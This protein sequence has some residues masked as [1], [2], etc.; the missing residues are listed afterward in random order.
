MA[1]EKKILSSILSK[2]NSWLGPKILYDNK[3][4]HAYKFMYMYKRW[5]Y[6][7]G[8]VCWYFSCKTTG[9]NRPVSIFRSDADIH[10]MGY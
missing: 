2:I 9:Y 5:I 10:F 1:N 8:L 3:M 6:L 7:F 4:V